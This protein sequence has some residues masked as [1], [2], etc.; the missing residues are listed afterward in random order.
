MI[1]L[2]KNTILIAQFY[3]VVS[4]SHQPSKWGETPKQYNIQYLF[5]NITTH[6]HFWSG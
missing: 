3:I 5:F 4:V 6:D 2:E 1:K